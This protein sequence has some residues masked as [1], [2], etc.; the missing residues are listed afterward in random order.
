MTAQARSTDRPSQRAQAVAAAG[1]I[2]YVLVGVVFALVML[3]L[4]MVFSASFSR[5]GPTFFRRQ[6][7]WV[8]VGTLAF[9]FMLFF[10]YRRWAKL[11]VPVMAVTLGLLVAV[12]VVGQDIHGATR[13][14]F[15]GRIQPSEFAKMAVVIYAA[16]W[17]VSSGRTLADTGGGLLQFTA[18]MAVVAG[19]ILL[20]RS[21]SMTIIILVIGYTIFFVGGGNVKQ[22][23]LVMALGLPA[24][25]FAMYRTGYAQERIQRWAAVLLNPQ[26]ADPD[27]LRIIQVL[28]S[29]QGIGTSPADWAVKDAVPLLWSDYIF[30]NIG[31]DLTI[32]GMIAVLLAYLLI[33]YR[34]LGI[35]LNAEHAFGSMLAIGITTWL[36]TQAAVHIGASLAVIPSTGQPLPFISYGGS[37]L[38]MCMAAAGLLANVSRFA[39][40][41]KAPHA[42][43]AF[44]WRDWRS[45]LSDSRSRRGTEPA[46]SAP[47]GRDAEHA[48]PRRGSGGKAG[49]SGRRSGGKKRTYRS[50]TWSGR[51][52]NGG[53]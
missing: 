19:L 41:K 53:R 9:L 30:A 27:T 50:E 14:L 13:T 37:S 16:A 29:G 18:I 26:G 5:V 24:L 40:E 52:R 45:H 38:V 33:G 4:V 2:D 3:G 7:M 1:Q 47:A 42:Y 39:Q 6:L 25:A 20:E 21:F 34:G 22:L 15:N 11:A 23:L 10:P 35:A 8:G 31:H 44:G 51:Y 12:L 17:V 46:E 43:L 49:T 48:A 28:R 32:V 36:V